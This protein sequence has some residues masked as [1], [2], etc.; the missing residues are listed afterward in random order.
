MTV[1]PAKRP[2]VFCT[3]WPER[4]RDLERAPFVA[5][6]NKSHLAEVV[7][8]VREG[9]SCEVPAVTR[10]LHELIDGEARG[11]LRDIVAPHWQE[12]AAPDHDEI[13]LVLVNRLAAWFKEPWRRGFTGMPARKRQRACSKRAVTASCTCPST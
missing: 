12:M 7:T 3:A 5:V 4:V 9:L 6:V 8:A 2:V 10:N 11:F 1:A 13:V